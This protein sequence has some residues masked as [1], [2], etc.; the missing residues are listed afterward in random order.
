MKLKRLRLSN[1]QSFGEVPTIVDFE[2]MTFL[3]GPNGVGKTAVLQ[4][5]ARLFAFDPSLRKVRRTDFNVSPDKLLKGG[6]GDLKLWIEADFEFPELGAAK[7]KFATV[8]GQFAHMGL[9][10][11]D[12]IPRVRFRLDATLDEN[13]EIDE[14]LRY[15]NQADAFGAPAKT[16]PVMKYARNALHVHY[17]P[18]RR[19]PADHISYA[20]GSLLGRLLRAAD[21]K[22]ERETIAKATSEISALLA[23]N[24]AMVSVGA[25]LKSQW[26]ALHQG[27][28]YKN[29]SVSFERNEMEALLRH[30]TVGFDAGPDT[31]T[32]DFTRLSDGQRS[33]LYV[34]L[35][36]AAQVV[37]RKVLAKELQGF[38]VDRLKPPVFTL[39]AVEEPENSLS[40]HY[41]GR[42]IRQLDEFAGN[43]DGQAIVATHAPSILRRVPPERVRYLRLNAA[44]ETQ[45]AKVTLP[46]EADE[47]HKFV[48]EAVQ[49]F[50]ELYFSRLVV[51][52]EGDSEEIVLPRFLHAHGLGADDTAISVVPLG[53][54]HVNHFWR[55]LSGLGI[56]HVTLLDLDAGRYQGGWGRLKYAVSQL[57]RVAP[58]G[59]QLEKVDPAK[60]PGW[61]AA[62]S[63]TS[64]NGRKW[65]D[66]LE[67]RSV[68]FSAPLDLDF[69]MLSRFPDA[70]GVSPDELGDPDVEIVTAVLG[71]KHGNPDQYSAEAKKMFGAYH[72]RFKL[73]SKP[74]NHVSA[75][76]VLD[77]KA[78]AAQ[79]PDTIQRLLVAVT[80]RIAE[81]PE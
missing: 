15:V 33:L 51:L 28:Y 43:H 68:F 38:D 78:L 81:S 2:P 60:M 48:R 26:G 11:A 57:K 67:S 56:P 62:E 20:A 1:F 25:E 69:L 75:M 24:L 29:P 14:E 40:P 72:S 22:A 74:T 79:T 7:G 61:D 6:V 31:G 73:G 65:L 37:G 12:G 9:E 21:W 23:K 18:A 53:G 45:V 13:G 55:L 42:L 35:V 8:P 50:P 16:S 46:A 80:K 71:K 5:L 36:L 41:L 70:Y 58:P 47:A 34:S 3:L 17:L 19:D 32:V 27:Q 39:I 10:S 49:A 77:A 76:S 64:E 54:R 59:D 30:L 63:V 44:R 4:G 52:G 66:Y